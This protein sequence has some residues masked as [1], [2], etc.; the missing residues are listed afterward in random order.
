[1]EFPDSQIIYINP[2][3]FFEPVANTEKIILPSNDT[4]E[5]SFDT[6]RH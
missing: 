3:D 1:M 4:R 6:Q 5:F 2:P